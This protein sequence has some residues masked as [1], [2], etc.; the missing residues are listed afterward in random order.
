ASSARAS[1]GT[2]GSSTAG[3]RDSDASP[4]NDG[5]SCAE[6]CTGLACV[7]AEAGAGASNSVTGSVASVLPTLSSVAALAPLPGPLR[8]TAFDAG[9]LSEPPPPKN[10]S[11]TAI[12]TKATPETSTQGRLRSLRRLA[13]A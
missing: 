8:C 2:V 10:H 1:S 6:G 5:C 3:A 7:T 11:A 9:A 13:S 4:G 12:T